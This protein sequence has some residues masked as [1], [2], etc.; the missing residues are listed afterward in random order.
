MNNFKRT[1]NE[2]IDM[3]VNERETFLML[4]FP[5]L[6]FIFFWA[7]CCFV[8][9]CVCFSAYSKQPVDVLDVAHVFNADLFPLRARK[10]GRISE[11]STWVVKRKF[12]VF[13]RDCSETPTI[14]FFD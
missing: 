6:Q 1:A 9:V 12:D 4:P 13:L 7:V 3:V 11:V 2:P 10:C 8:C 14:P 5:S